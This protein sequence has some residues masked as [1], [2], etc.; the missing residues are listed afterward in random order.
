MHRSTASID[1]ASHADPDEF[2]DVQ[3]MQKDEHWGSDEVGVDLQQ[4]NGENLP[5]SE[6]GAAVSVEPAEKSSPEHSQESSDHEGVPSARNSHEETLGPDH[7][8]SN[9]QT[10]E[11][12]STVTVEANAEN[13]A[14]ADPQV[15]MQSA[16]A[17]PVT[18]SIEKL[19]LKNA[20]EDSFDKNHI[21]S[22][23]D[24]PGNKSSEELY[25][26]SEALSA[27]GATSAKDLDQFKGSL[28]E[29]DLQSHSQLTHGNL[30]ATEEEDDFGDFAEEEFGEDFVEAPAS[31]IVTGGSSGSSYSS[32]ANSAPNSGSSAPSGAGPFSGSSL[33]CID[34]DAPISQ[35]RET[36]TEILPDF[37]SNQAESNLEWNLSREPFREIEGL[38]QVLVNEPSRKLFAELGEPAPIASTP[39]NWTQSATRRQHLISLGIPVNLD[40]VHETSRT[41]KVMP[42]LK[43][44]VEAPKDTSN[45]VDSSGGALTNEPPTVSSRTSRT[46]EDS[47][48]RTPREEPPNVNMERVEQLINL[49]ES[50]LVLKSLTEL[51]EIAREM[52]SLTQQTSNLLAH[53]LMVREALNSDSEM[54][55]GMIRD[56]V[57]GAST[58]HASTNKHSK[59]GFLSRAS[60]L[61]RSRPETPN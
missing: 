28:E 10:N 33:K 49:S 34:L 23:I 42:P 40:E 30:D 51:R 44:H 15:N 31:S 17:A 12:N 57:A 24:Q 29:E 2:Y 54:L 36:L 41:Q 18:D 50:Q 22:P 48:A 58:K 35:M 4:H 61:R 55:N 38:S 53:H 8:E 26:S 13:S 47:S 52:R 19:A 9:E 39:L 11:P 45:E 59:R 21:K 37:M 7:S 43:L 32:A 5:A 1:D 27:H 46:E 20:D 60:S 14:E 56:L 3:D 16:N 25:D 6:D